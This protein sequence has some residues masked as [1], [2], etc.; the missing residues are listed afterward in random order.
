MKYRSRAYKLYL[1]P[2]FITIVVLVGVP[3]GYAIYL[4]LMDYDFF[5]GLNTFTGLANYSAI[6]H[7]LSFLRAFLRTTLYVT[8]VNAAN[9]GIAFPMAIV[10]SQMKSRWRSILV[11]LFVLPMLLIPVAAATFWRMI[12]YSPPYAE[13]N[14][15]FGIGLD[16]SLLASSDTALWAVMLVDI[17][18]WTPWVFLPLLG[19]LE[20]LD[21]EPLEA[22]QIEGASGLRIIW[23]IILPLLKP[24][25]IV[26]LSIKAIQT[27]QVFSYIWAI[28]RGGPGGS[29]HSLSTYI[30]SKAF[31]VLN[32][33]YGSALSMVMVLC[34]IGLSTGL[35]IYMAR[36][37]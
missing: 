7:D 6:L 17:W 12:M 36:S 27:F 26:V 25:I 8:V 2:A 35:F 30:Y 11:V 29:S 18:G 33:G 10:I 28:T 1:A 15:L 31:T 34:A 32:Y 19:G 22:A 4:S 24:I 13:F 9:F 20:G 14:R 21:P 16:Q 5:L 23:N 3:T 37:K